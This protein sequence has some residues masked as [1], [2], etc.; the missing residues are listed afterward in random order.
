ML[1]LCIFC[2]HVL[3]NI[4]CELWHDIWSHTHLLQFNGLAHKHRTE[5]L[6]K[7]FICLHNRCACGHIRFHAMWQ[8]AACAQKFVGM[9]SFA[10]TCMANIWRI[11]VKKSYLEDMQNRVYIR[12]QIFLTTVG[13]AI[14]HKRLSWYLEANLWTIIFWTCNCW[15]INRLKNFSQ[16]KCLQVDP[17]S[18]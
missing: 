8:S 2:P 18:T 16:T 17:K 1:S 14:I 4:R 11:Q 7:F 6:C 5:T 9:P 3:F 10:G 13:T 12:N 15:E